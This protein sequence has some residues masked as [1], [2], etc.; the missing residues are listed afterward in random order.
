MRMNEYTQA[1]RCALAAGLALV[2]PVQAA[3]MPAGGDPAAVVVLVNTAPITT[4]ELDQ[5]TQHS[6]K[7]REEVLNELI[8]RRL[9]EQAARQQGMDQDPVLRQQGETLER[10]L[11]VGALQRDVTDGAASEA[12]V[13]AYYDAH[14]DD[15][16][17]ERIHLRHILVK[18]PAVAESVLEKLHGGADFAALEQEYS[19]DS[20]VSPG[21]DLGS[22]VRGKMDPEF[23]AAAF[24][25]QKPGDLSGVVRSKFGYHVIQL[26]DPPVSQ[27]RPFGQ[28]QG[29]IRRQLTR[30]ALADYLD[31]LR[32]QAEIV[33]SEPGSK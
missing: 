17:S 15:Y 13:R 16:T 14:I 19:V 10:R 33:Y 2:A 5:A 27:T 9:L 30:T 21:G 26:V 12:A 8:E 24:A 1:I 22:L 7:S 6:R 31:K 23:E 20:A 32:A 25:L 28:V 3:D 18:D 29:M 4:D 11:L